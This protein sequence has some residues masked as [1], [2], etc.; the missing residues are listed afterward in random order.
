MTRPAGLQ[1]PRSGSRRLT[2]VVDWEHACLGPPQVDIGHCRLNFL[3]QTPELADHLA[4]AWCE[5]TG[6]RYDP[7]AD[8]AAIV[9][10]VDGLRRH[11]PGSRA[12]W[13]IEDAL[14]RAV[15][16]LAPR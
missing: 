9:G 7:W 14:R 16:E 15:D 5:V 1:T 12:R 6:S 8:I 3:Y 2:G 11:P 4:D 13:S 10:L